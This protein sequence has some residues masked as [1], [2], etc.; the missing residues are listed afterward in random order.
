MGLRIAED[1]LGELVV[2]DRG[3][4][5]IRAEQA[6]WVFAV[7]GRAPRGVRRR[8]AEAADLHNHFWCRVQCRWG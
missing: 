2:T 6:R 8:L 7:S 1:P 5:G 4:Y 3:R